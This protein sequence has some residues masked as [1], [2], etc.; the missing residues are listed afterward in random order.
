[1]ASS[2]AIDFYAFSWSAPRKP[3]RN[4]IET[5]QRKSQKI[6]TAP[7]WGCLRNN[8]VSKVLA[9]KRA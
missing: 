3:A 9:V 1:M 4:L 8:T 5:A 6:E 7:P 2:K